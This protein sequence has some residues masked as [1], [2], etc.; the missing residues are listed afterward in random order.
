MI[1]TRRFLEALKRE[2][3]SPI[4]SRGQVL[5]L[6]DIGML[7]I[8]RGKSSR[9]GA[10][11]PLLERFERQITLRSPR[12]G[13]LQTGLHLDLHSQA[14]HPDRGRQR[15]WSLEHCVQ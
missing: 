1:T 15:E 14:P 5:Q 9:V 3:L 4:Q 8:V 11:V 7:E 10:D 6:F 12:R 2:V 13:L